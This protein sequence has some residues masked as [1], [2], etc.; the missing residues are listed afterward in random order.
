V[1][2]L[3]TMVEEVVVAVIIYAVEVVI[4]LVDIV[5]L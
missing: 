2:T 4:V 5:A 1:V 3:G